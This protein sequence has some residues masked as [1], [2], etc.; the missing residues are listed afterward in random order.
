MKKVA[1]VTD[2]TAALTQALAAELGIVVAPASFA[3]ADER[4]VDGTVPWA[5]VYR[6]MRTDG[7]APRSFGV[8]EA[9]FRGAFDGVLKEADALFCLLAPFDVNPS[10]TTACAAMLAIQF[11]EP[12]ARIKVA[13]A[14][15]GSAGL[16]ALMISLAGMVAAGA[17][18]DELVAAV[19]ALEPQADSL[20]VIR[21]TDWM[22]RAGK[23]HLV[24]ERLGALDGA[25]PV[26]RVGTR[27]TAVLAKDGFDAALEEAVAAV[28]KRAGGRKVNAVV[29]H[30]D[31]AA[32]A[33]R[34]AIALSG[35]YDVAKL[36]VSELPVTHGAQLG[37]GAVTIG[38]CPV[39]EGMD[40]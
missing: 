1:L 30:A 13:N 37:P 40:A 22:E 14:G 27:I 18:T 39:M 36:V 4:S 32:D 33:E 23:L 28:G 3:F 15:V 9:A 16:G 2:S 34:A 20:A 24:E 38:L 5:D 31:A 29:A 17:G 25:S 26:V 10:F 11:D 7:L 6:R 19:D 8:A 35:R 21:D 12:D